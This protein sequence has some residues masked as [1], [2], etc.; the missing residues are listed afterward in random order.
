MSELGG[1][2]EL[3][4]AVGVAVTLVWFVWS[5]FV[6]RYWRAVRMRHARERREMEDA[7]RRG[8]E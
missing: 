3:L 1:L 2:F 8:R 6:R 7:A 4:L 5:V